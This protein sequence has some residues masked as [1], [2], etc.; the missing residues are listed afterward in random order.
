VN[1]IISASSPHSFLGINMQ[2]RSCV[3]RTAGNRY[4]HLVLR[5]GGGRPNYDTVSVALAERRWPR[6]SC[7]TTSWSI[8]RTPTATRSPSCSRW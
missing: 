5:G 8:A 4:G 2:G 1:A 6:P 7:R 3:V